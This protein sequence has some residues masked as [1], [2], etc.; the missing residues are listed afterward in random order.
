VLLVVDFG[1]GPRKV[2]DFDGSIVGFG[3]TPAEA[4]P[5][6][7]PVVT[8][9]GRRIELG[10]LP[11]PPVDLLAVAQDRKW[12]SIDTI[13]V[14]KSAL[15][16]GLVAGGLYEGTRRGGSDEAALAMLA[17]GLL[18]K[19]TSQAD[20]RQWEMLPRTVFLL[21]LK[22]PPGSREITVSF[23]SIPGLTQTWQNLPVPA[24]GEATFYYRMQLYQQ[25]AFIWPPPDP[26]AALM[27]RQRQ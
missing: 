1:Y 25:A 8:V 5:I 3:P 20:V 6:P 13:R 9:D 7:R 19:A 27:A 10:G 22:L 17:T 16:T 24:E 2:T 21:P 18:L 4:G 12:Q 23:P 11:V 14:V 15:G 26:Q